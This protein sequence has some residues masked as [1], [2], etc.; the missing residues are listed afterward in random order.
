[1][2]P[3]LFKMYSTEWIMSRLHNKSV[4]CVCAVFPFAMIV[5]VKKFCQA[6]CVSLYNNTVCGHYAKILSQERLLG[7][8]QCML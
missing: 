8:C 7:L 4:W 3:S 2:A 6:K 1:M 5:C